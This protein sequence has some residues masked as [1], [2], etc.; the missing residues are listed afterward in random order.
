MPR[1]VGK[2]TRQ[3]VLTL[4][5]VFLAGAVVLSARLPSGIDDGHSIER[6]LSAKDAALRSY[7]AYR[8][9]EAG[10][11]GGKIRGRLCACTE[12]EP[13][14]NFTYSVVREDGSEL[15][16][17]LVLH[18]AL[19]AERSFIAS[20]E[21]EKGALSRANYDFAAGGGDGT[22][23][24]RIAM[25]PRRQDTLLVDGSMLLRPEDADL[26]RVEGLLSKRPS[27]WTRR[28][29]VVRQYARIDGIRVPVS[30]QSTAQI[31]F[32][33][34]SLFSMT[35]DYQSINDRPVPGAAANVCTGAREHRAPS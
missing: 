23:L 29:E 25:K 33:G 24:I 6:F 34:T 21:I 18:A 16:R 17:R 28:V 22:G 35:Y 13:A 9:L 12:L 20:G 5:A 27:F 11:R 8:V 19:E 32:V 1:P 3:S 2:V 30:M 4:W 10:T 26:V 31:L 7:R 15:V 14:G